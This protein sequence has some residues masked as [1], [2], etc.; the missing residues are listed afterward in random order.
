MQHR[1][2]LTIG[3]L[4]SVLS[5]AR[6]PTYEETFALS[7]FRLEHFDTYNPILNQ[8]RMD[9]MARAEHPEYYDYDAYFD[10]TGELRYAFF[11]SESYGF[12]Q[13]F[14]YD[15]QGRLSRVEIYPILGD[16]IDRSTEVDERKYFY[17]GNVLLLVRDT[18][19]D[20]LLFLDG[21]SATVYIG[22]LARGKSEF[23]V[24][25]VSVGEFY[26]ALLH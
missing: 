11:R 7:R 3:V 18:L 2:V 16:R 21:D 6:E 9:P 15:D 10:N 26:V 13:D 19:N 20:E 17:R 14:S 22:V 4:L 1:L 24:E 5:C 8:F 12:L 25:R 23:R